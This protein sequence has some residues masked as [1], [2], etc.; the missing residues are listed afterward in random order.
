MWFLFGLA[1]IRLIP[2]IYV[3]RASNQMLT[4]HLCGVNFAAVQLWGSIILFVFTLIGSI[5]Q[6]LNS[7]GGQSCY[8]YD[9]DESYY[10]HYIY[11]YYGPS[12]V[13]LGIVGPI[14]SFLH[15]IVLSVCCYELWKGMRMKALKAQEMMQSSQ[16]A[17]VQAT[18]NPYFAY[19][20]QAPQ[21]FNLNPY[22]Y[23]TNPSPGQ[24]HG[25]QQQ[26]DQDASAPPSYHF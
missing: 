21:P 8:D 25:Q 15:L 19:A 4:S 18:Y 6:Q 5:L 7:N 11:N 23:Y 24:Y 1:A 3:Y 14:L 9:F 22:A 10:C 12:M 26:Q 2:S 20:P 13:M 16:Q 17:Q